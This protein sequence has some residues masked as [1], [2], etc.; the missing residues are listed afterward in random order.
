MLRNALARASLGRGIGGRLAHTSAPHSSAQLAE[1]KQPSVVTEEIP[2]PQ[3]KAALARLGQLQDTRAAVF[4]GDYQKSV[5][6]YI[7]DADGNQLLDLYCQIAS[8]PIGYNNAALLKAASSPEMAA[9]LAN[10][11]ALGVYPP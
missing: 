10:R 8:V 9:T 2:G 11:P 1:P 6:N 4:A 3:S 5:G 7:V